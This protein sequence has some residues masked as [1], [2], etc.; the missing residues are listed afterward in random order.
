[1]CI[2]DSIKSDLFIEWAFS[3]NE[4]FV[5]KT[6]RMNDVQCVTDTV[7]IVSVT[8]ITVTNH[9]YDV[10]NFVVEQ[11]IIYIINIVTFSPV[12]SPNLT[13]NSDQM[14]CFIEVISYS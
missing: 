6:C 2:R 1:M 12:I 14:I 11:T 5:S 4:H 9:I 13:A 3:V 10:S 8:L 7:T